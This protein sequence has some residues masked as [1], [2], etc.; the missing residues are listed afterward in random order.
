MRRSGLSQ[1]TSGKGDLT[2]DRELLG[3]GQGEPRNTLLA[4][5]FSIAAHYSCLFC[6]LLTYL[7]GEVRGW[8]RACTSG[9]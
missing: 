6:C 3:E 7:N 8:G 5:W 1:C 4:R 9:V 2:D